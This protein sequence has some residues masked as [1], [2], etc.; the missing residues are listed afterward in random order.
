[1]VRRGQRLPA[2]ELVFT[3]R[4]HK[5]TIAEPRNLSPRAVRHGPVR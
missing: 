4:V 3:A 5:F 1:V 2:A